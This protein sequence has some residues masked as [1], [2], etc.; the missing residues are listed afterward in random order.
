[1]DIG[2]EN[3]TAQERERVIEILKTCDKAI[4]FSDV[5]RG[6][7]DPRYAKPARIYTIPHVPWNDAGWKY[8][9]KEK[10]EVIAFL[11]E[12]MVSHVAQPSDSAYA[13]RWF[14]LRKPNGKIRWIQD[15]LKVNAVTI[16][17]VG[18]V[19]HSDLLAEGAAGRSIYSVCDLFSGYDEVPLDPRDRHLT[20]MHTPLGLIQMMVVPMG[21]TN[22]V[23]VFQ[24][25]MVAVLK[26]FIP[27]KVEVFLDDFPIKGL[28]HRMRQR[29]YLELEDSS[30]S[31]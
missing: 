8:A 10:E 17:D 15:L 4:A 5:Q 19:P 28:V 27:D 22:G 14:F 3:L 26:D 24:R 9:Q 21:W 20:A 12:K 16:R 11:K 29:L 23:A 7:I 6:R 18:S 25:A 1:M 2:D 31:T 30:S 13:N